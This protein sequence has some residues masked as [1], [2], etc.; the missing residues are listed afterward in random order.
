MLTFQHNKH[1]AERQHIADFIY[2]VPGPYYVIEHKPN[3]NLTGPMWTV[4]KD[5][6]V[7]VEGP[8]LE[9]D[10]QVC[11]RWGKG[12]EP[13]TTVGWGSGDGIHVARFAP[14]HGEEG[15]IQAL[16][17]AFALVR[18]SRINGFDDEVP[19]AEHLRID[20]PAFED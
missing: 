14:T 2:P 20:E 17:N 6:Y 18:A 16:A 3:P 1:P 11:R 10:I 15:R 19:A 5:D 8:N 12:V 9:R 13:G 4:V 7:C